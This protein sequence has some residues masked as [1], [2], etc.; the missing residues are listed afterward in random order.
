MPPTRSES[1]RTS[2]SSQPPPSACPCI[3]AITGRGNL[4]TRSNTCCMRLA[5]SRMAPPW[6]ANLPAFC[7]IIF[8]SAPAQEVLRM[9][10]GQHQHARRFVRVQLGAELIEIVDERVGDGIRR[11]IVDGNPYH[12]FVQALHVQ[13]G[14]GHGST[15]SQAQAVRLVQAPRDNQ[16][17][18]LVRALE[19]VVRLSHRGRASR[20]DG[21]LGRRGPSSLQAV[22]RRHRAPFCQRALC[23]S[24]ASFAFGWPQSPSMRPPRSAS[25]RP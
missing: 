10:R 3:A 12:P 7:V 6:P 17:L 4:A 19:D 21:R 11:R 24:A 18:N 13:C 23:T 1:H 20:R 16:V 14:I 5:A 8:R 22:R 2:A 25:D 9:V 15:S